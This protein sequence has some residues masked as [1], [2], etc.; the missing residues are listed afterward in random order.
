MSPSSLSPAQ[1]TEHR[2]PGDAS[3]ACGP[4]QTTQ[5]DPVSSR[6]ALVRRLAQLATQEPVTVC[7]AIYNEKGVKLLGRGVR[8]DAT[9]YERLQKHRL[10]APIETCVAPDN[11]VT[12][13]QLVEEA[14]Q[15]LEQFPLMGRLCDPARLRRAAPVLLGRV[16]LPH[17]LAVHLTT[18]RALH[19]DLFDHSIL[20][21]LACM[22]LGGYEFHTEYDRVMLAAV[23]LFHD[24]G[25]LHTDQA[26]LAGEPDL[27]PAQRRHITAHPLTSAMLVQ[28]HREFPSTVM[29]AVLQHHER[30]DGTGYPKALADKAFTPWGRIASAAEMVTAILLGG[31]MVDEVRLETLL[32]LNTGQFDPLLRDAVSRACADGHNLGVGL[33]AVATDELESALAALWE[34]L[35]GWKQCVGAGTGDR[36]MQAASRRM[37]SVHRALAK[38]GLDTSFS[39]STEFLARASASERGELTLV[40]REV[41]YQIRLAAQALQ[42]FDGVDPQLPQS[43]A[44]WSRSASAR[45][46]AEPTQL[47]QAAA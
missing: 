26:V 40:V 36:R 23:G 32:R 28:P 11:M 19:K 17:G 3:R 8:V 45:T 34:S 44:A 42:E 38:V 1:P 20:T 21:A 2:P 27:T 30:L 29:S 9:L 7:T 46:F 43:V 33:H 35:A 18:A 16:P 15:L 24:L 25:M 6:L 22:A 31:G 37:A 12:S 4:E 13:A 39:R 14:G 5:A 41:K 47:G 10:L